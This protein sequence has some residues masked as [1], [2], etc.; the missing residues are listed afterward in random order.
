MNGDS[1]DFQY[2][3]SHG[4][5]YG[6]RITLARQPDTGKYDGRAQAYEGDIGR[7]AFVGNGYALAPFDAASDDDAYAEALRRVGE[8]IEAGTL[9]TPAILGREAP[10][11]EAMRD[12]EEAGA[13]PDRAKFT[14]VWR[15]DAL[16]RE[17]AGQA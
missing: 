16:G 7:S 2:T 9:I 13:E 12:R 8:Q 11:L 4:L 5:T 15:G 6:V 14:D 17:N 10:A 1:K 3:T